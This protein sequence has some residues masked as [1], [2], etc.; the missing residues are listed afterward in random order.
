MS[1]EIVAKAGR[2]VAKAGIS[3]VE[4]SRRAFGFFGEI[5]PDADNPVLEEIE[6][7]EDGKNWLVTVGYD[8]L[9]PR[10]QG[11][12]IPKF[13]QI[14]IRKLKTIKVN[15]KTGAVSS[16]KIHILD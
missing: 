16:M 13:L 2:R 9:P 6:L 10:P 3:A 12:M 7:S 14:P 4:A 8:E 11:S 15:A 5:F 1:T